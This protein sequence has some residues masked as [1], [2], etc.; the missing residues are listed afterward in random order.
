MSTFEP[1]I[2]GFCCSWCSYA[3]ADLAGVSRTQYAHNI[4]IVRVMCSGR[5][6]PKFVIS[7]FLSGADGVMVLGCHPG[8][9]HYTTGNYE[10]MNA[11]VETRMLLNYIGLDPG[12]LALD[13]AS[14]AEG[15]RFA[16]MVNSFTEQVRK[17]GPLGSAEEM[18]AEELEFELKAAKLAA[19]SRRLRG[20]SGKQTEFT[21]E[22]NK[23]GEVFTR[24][25]MDR[26]LEGVI[27]DEIPIS[28]ILLLTQEEP[29]SVKEIAGRIGVSSPRV[30][31]YVVALRRK[32]FLEL[33]GIKETSPLYVASAKGKD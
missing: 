28:K 12:R 17:L 19:E 29:L 10:A 2:L 27:A 4:V 6:D 31:K 8:D 14:A 18:S 25:E 11:V 16:E 13:W 23:Y 7:G 26:V 21:T 9:C 24:H 5:V 3:A 22:G 1:K 32:G 33:D 15:G 30:L 20:V